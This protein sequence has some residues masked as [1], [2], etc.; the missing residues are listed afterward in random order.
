LI[1]QAEEKD[2]LRFD[3]FRSQQTASVHAGSATESCVSEQILYR[4]IYHKFAFA[5]TCTIRSTPN[6]FPR[7]N[8]PIG[9]GVS[10]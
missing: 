5:L 9:F 8:A 7:C 6:R 4:T 10:P 1:R 2:C 3:P